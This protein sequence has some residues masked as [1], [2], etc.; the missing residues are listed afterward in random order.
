MIGIFGGTGVTGS[1]VVAALKEKGADF[2][3]IVRDLKAAKSKL[4]KDVKIV[5]GDLSDPLSLD[6]ALDGLD[7]LYLLCGHSPI[8][9]DQL[10]NGVEAAKRAGISY[11]V[12]SSGTES[13][14]REDSPSEI[15][16]MHFHVENA[17]RGSGINWAI[18]RPNYFMSNLIA[19]AEP[20]VNFGKII[21]PLPPETTISMIHPLDIGECVTELLTNQ[22]RADQEYFLTGSA[23]TMSGVVETISAVIGTEVEYMQ[24]PAETARKTMEDKGMPEWLLAHMGGMMGL[25]AKG[26]A[27]KETDWVQNLTGHPPRTLTE[28]LSGVKAKFGE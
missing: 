25:V 12:Y 10:I 2:T 3:C 24:V 4:G 5:Q 1:Q 21:M 20:V 6:A 9:R 23:I 13:G 18:A 26:G 11:I 14:I 28:W 8:L 19:M 27:A 22:D 17:V 7:T 15:M 16:R